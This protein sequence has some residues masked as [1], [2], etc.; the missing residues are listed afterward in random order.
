MVKV[1]DKNSVKENVVKVQDHNHKTSIPCVIFFNI[2]RRN[3][4]CSLRKRNRISST[5]T[6]FV[7]QLLN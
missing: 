2:I 4:T 5:A 3:R 7:K 6:V 1:Q